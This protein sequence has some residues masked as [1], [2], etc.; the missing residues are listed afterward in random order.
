MIWI[1]LG[2]DKSGLRSIAIVGTYA[3]LPAG[4]SMKGF[5]IRPTN[6]SLEVPCTHPS[7]WIEGWGEAPHVTSRVKQKGRMS[8][9]TINERTC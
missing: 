7:T 8:D 2:Y 4:K 6:S 1:R 3:S 9:V 5:L